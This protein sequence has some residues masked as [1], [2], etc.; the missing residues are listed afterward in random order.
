MQ[1]KKVSVRFTDDK[2]NNVNLNVEGELN[3]ETLVTYLSALGCFEKNNTFVEAFESRDTTEGTFDSEVKKRVEGPRSLNDEVKLVVDSLAGGWF[4]SKDVCRVYRE[5]FN[6]EILLGK[7]STYLARM[8]DRGFL[9]RLKSGK[10][11]RYTVQIKEP[12]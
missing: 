8:Y 6:K 3:V 11:F 10:L 2:G 1:R 4:T 7:V 12:A 5:R 9:T